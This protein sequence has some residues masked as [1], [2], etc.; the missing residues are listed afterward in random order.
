MFVENDQ[1]FQYQYKQFQILDQRYRVPMYPLDEIQ[2]YLSQQILQIRTDRGFQLL[3]G[4]WTKITL[5]KILS[6][7]L[8]NVKI[9]LCEI[10]IAKSWPTI[11]NKL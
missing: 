2:T 3:T 9:D 4:K 6:R 7:E 11:K 1:C 10:Q 8:D 5:N